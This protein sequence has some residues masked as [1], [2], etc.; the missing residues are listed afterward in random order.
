MWMSIT[1]PC[2]TAQILDQLHLTSL[3]FAGAHIS[4]TAAARAENRIDADAVK[5]LCD[6]LTHPSGPAHLTSLNLEGT[7]SEM[8]SDIDWNTSSCCHHADAQETT[9][10]M[11]ARPTCVR[12]SFALQHF[13][14]SQSSTSKVLVHHRVEEMRGGRRGDA[15]WKVNGA[16]EQ[17]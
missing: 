12:R 17:V 7:L 10:V 4:I 15:W 3:S 2:C 14:T 13:R 11:R 8:Q 1:P 16:F 6:T 9:S 5:I